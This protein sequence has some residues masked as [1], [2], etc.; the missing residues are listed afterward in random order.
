MAGKFVMS[1]LREYY[2]VRDRLAEKLAAIENERYY[3]IFFVGP[4]VVGRLIDSIIKEKGLKMG[5][6]K[7]LMNFSNG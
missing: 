7:F 3:R 2:D 4:S 5:D 6:Q 1:R